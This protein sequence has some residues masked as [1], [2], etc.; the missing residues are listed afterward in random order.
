MELTEEQLDIVEKVKGKRIPGLWDVRCQQYLDNKSKTSTKKAVKVD[1]TSQ[2]ISNSLFL[3]QIMA[4]YRG[5]EG[6]VK[7]KNGAGTVDT[8]ASTRSWN[9]SITKDVLETTAH[10]ATTRAYVGSFID[11]SGSVELLYTGSTGDETQEFLKD[12]LVAQD[13]ADAQFE[14]YLSTSGSKKLA[15]N[16]LIT[17]AEFSTSVGDL[18]VVNIS[19][20]MN[21]ALTSDAI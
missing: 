4:F 20:Q 10:G 21:G 12:V 17:G 18:Q 2:T 5:E 15:F 19:F 16:G 9:F 14:L 7:F 1:S 8:V 6:S 13:A 11:G 3:F